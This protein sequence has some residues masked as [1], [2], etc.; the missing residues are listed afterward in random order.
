MDERITISDKQRQSLNPLA[1][2]PALE[3]DTVGDE[4][5]GMLQADACRE[6]SEGRTI[7]ETYPAQD[8]ALSL[9]W[10]EPDLDEYDFDGCPRDSAS[11]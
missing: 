3:A 6:L 1:G 10:N 7:V 5:L 2:S 8:D 9:V 4:Q 11:N